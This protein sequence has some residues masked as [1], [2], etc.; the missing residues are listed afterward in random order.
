MREEP[1]VTTRVQG[2]GR[3]SQRVTGSRT[4][5]AMPTS[6]TVRATMQRLGGFML[7]TWS[8]GRPTMLRGQAPEPVRTTRE[9]R[10]PAAMARC[11]RRGQ[12]GRV[13]SA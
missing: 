1:A 8:P 11:A 9:A 3:C 4:S 7:E 13:P 5:M 6:Q 2:R 12:P 10:P